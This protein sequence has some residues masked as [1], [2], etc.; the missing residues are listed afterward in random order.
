MATQCGTF[1]RGLGRVPADVAA[2]LCCSA[3]LGGVHHRRD[4]A[5]ATPQRSEVTTTFLCLFNHSQSPKSSFFV[6]V[7]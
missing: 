6:L 4:N 5:E 2:S 1:G 3:A 7:E